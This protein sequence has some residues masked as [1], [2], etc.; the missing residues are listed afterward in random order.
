MALQLTIV[1]L[2]SGANPMTS[3]FTTA[4]AVVVVED[5]VFKVEENILFSKRT[6]LLIALKLTIVGLA[7]GANPTTYEFTTIHF[8]IKT[9][10]PS[11][12]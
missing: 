4:T 12:W 5:G 1:G 9:T 7:S 6:R 10:T 11:M 8:G 2:A 3:E